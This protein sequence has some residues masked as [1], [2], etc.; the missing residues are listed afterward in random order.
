MPDKKCRFIFLNG[1]YYTFHEA[2]K[3]YIKHYGFKKEVSW[4]KKTLSEAPSDYT[5]FI[6]SHG[7]PLNKDEYFKNGGEDAF[8]AVLDARNGGLKIAGWFYGHEH[9]DALKQSEGVNMCAIASQ[10]PYIP[11][12]WS[13][14][15]GAT[16][17]DNRDLET[18][19]QDLWDSVLV[20][21]RKREIKMVRFGA[22][23]DR[24]ITY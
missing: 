3:E 18:V 8:N 20:N 22:G 16:F 7:D 23:D 9:W 17:H 11:Q 2:E 21:C 19:N 10:T 24:I 4:L 14:P 1:H 6:F 5:V 13:A 15:P 12:L